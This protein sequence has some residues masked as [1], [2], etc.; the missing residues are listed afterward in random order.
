MPDLCSGFPR[1]DVME[2]AGEPSAAVWQVDWEDAMEHG[3]CVA[4]PARLHP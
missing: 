3:Q 2:I 4:D 1:H